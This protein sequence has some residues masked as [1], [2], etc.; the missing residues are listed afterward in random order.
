[1]DN[2]FGFVSPFLNSPPKQADDG[3]TGENHDDLLFGI[4]CMLLSRS[5]IPVSLICRV[6]RTAAAAAAQV[7]CVFPSCNNLFR[8]LS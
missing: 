8:R 4:S 7:V 5:Y 2:E 1:M 3:D 6:A